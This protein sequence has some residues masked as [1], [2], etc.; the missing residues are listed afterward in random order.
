MNVD[1]LLQ[2]KEFS[3]RQGLTLSYS[4]FFTQ[5]MLVEIGEAL[6]K[7]MRKDA[8]TRKTA[9]RVFH[10][11]VEQVQNV[12]RYSAEQVALE[13]DSVSLS[14]GTIAVGKSSEEAGIYYVACGNLIHARDISRLRD[15]LEL[16]ASMNADELKQYY[17]QQMRS[18]PG[19]HSKGAGVGFIEM[20]RKACRP[21]EY[22]FVPMRAEHS[23]FFLKAYIAEA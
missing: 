23:F 16:L 13:D 6:S 11:F 3:S 1:D 21:L 15:N 14:F 20:A 9:D 18:D 17:R 8:L 5:G 4:G 19:E 12:M 7:Q 2:L 22:A 10:I